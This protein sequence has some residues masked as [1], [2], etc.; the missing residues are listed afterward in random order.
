VADYVFTQP[1]IELDGE[2]VA[3][4]TNADLV[5]WRVGGPVRVLNARTNEEIRTSDCA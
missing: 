3:R 1:G 5:L 4:G 2:E